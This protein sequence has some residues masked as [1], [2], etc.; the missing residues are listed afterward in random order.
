MDALG[1]YYE[2]SG[3]RQ[4][5]DS[6][7]K[8]ENLSSNKCRTHSVKEKD[9]GNELG[10]VGMSGNVW[11]W[12]SDWYWDYPEGSVTDP[13]GPA[14]GDNR[15]FRG[16]CWGDYARNCRSADRGRDFP[17]LRNFSFG[18]RLCCSAGPREGG[19]EP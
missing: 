19:A 13:K 10:I 15:V 7:W 18:F 2:N 9:V 11:E 16:G 3:L 8:V 17:G 1:W 12:C 4:L 5:S 14:S 6:D